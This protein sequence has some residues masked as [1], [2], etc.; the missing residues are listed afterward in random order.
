MRLDEEQKKKG[1]SQCSEGWGKRIAKALECPVEMSDGL[2]EEDCSDLKEANINPLAIL[3]GLE[4][5]YCGF[6]KWD[7]EWLEC[8]GWPRIIE[9]SNCYGKFTYDKSSV[10]S[11]FE[12]D[13]DEDEDEKEEK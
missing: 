12:D 9:C 13:Y 8:M 7:K 5:P 6:T 10:L 2:Y 1:L 4:C 11:Y 3:P